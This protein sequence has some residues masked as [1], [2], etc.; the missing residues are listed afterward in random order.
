MTIQYTAEGVPYDDGLTPSPDTSGTSSG[1]PTQTVSPTLPASGGSTSTPTSNY[2]AGTVPTPQVTNLSDP[3]ALAQTGL[4]AA[5]TSTL[6]YQQIPQLY[7]APDTYGNPGAAINQTYATQQQEAFNPAQYQAQHPELQFQYTPIQND[8]SQ[9]LNYQAIGVN[10]QLAMGYQTATAGQAAVNQAPG[11]ATYQATQGQA[12]QG[13]VDPNS[14]MENQYAS[15]T[16]GVVDGSVPD[17]ARTAVTA[18]RQQ[19]T[20]LGLGASTMAGGATAAAILNA[21]FPMAQQNSNIIAQINSQNLAN[22]QQTL[23]SNTAMDNAAK[24]FNAQSVNQVNQFNA[25]LLAQINAQNADRLTAVSQFNSGQYNSL[26]QFLTNL[27]SQRQEFNAQ[28]Q[29]LV[30]QSNVQWR[31]AINV[32]NTAGINA[33]NQANVQ[34]LFNLSTSAQNQLWQT[35]QDEA[36]WALTSSENSQ[37]RLLSLVNS[38]LNRQTSLQILASQLNANMFNQLGS[39]ATNLLGGNLGSSLGNGISSLFGGSGGAGSGGGDFS[40]ALVSGGGDIGGDLGAFG[41][42]GTAFGG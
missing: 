21:A 34:N 20:S 16:K 9:E 36:S 7:Q 33:A 2:G 31:R 40:S 5:Q 4:Y 18:A 32:A 38:A 19:L 13:T 35:S 15:L 24:Q 28:N 39:F 14:L 3:N 23:L 27:N 29:L 30:D 26:S 8:P 6:P 17:W 42:F 37:N 11:A 22:R 12:A 10:N 1:T 41:D 25:S